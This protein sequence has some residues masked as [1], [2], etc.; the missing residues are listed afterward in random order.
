MKQA[1]KEAQ[2]T[3]DKLREDQESKVRFLIIGDIIF[4]TP[5]LLSLQTLSLNSLQ[6]DKTKLQ[7]QIQNGQ[8]KLEV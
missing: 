4:S 6:N 8:K 5:T 1:G 3:L 7:S 2:E